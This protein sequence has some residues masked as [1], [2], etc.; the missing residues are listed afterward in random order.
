M[1]VER[2]GWKEGGQ[3]PSDQVWWPQGRGDTVSGNAG[4][5]GRGTHLV[6]QG[7]MLKVEVEE[8]GPNDRGRGE[9]IS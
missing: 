1:R 5:V 7:G 4:A 8:F 3:E 2:N 6:G 9:W